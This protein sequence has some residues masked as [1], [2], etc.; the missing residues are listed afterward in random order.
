MM[1]T[2][3]RTNKMS[4]RFLALGLTLSL[5]FGMTL[6]AYASE[7]GEGGGTTPEVTA[8]A[9]SENQTP[10]E[11]SA[12]VQEI[13]AVQETAQEAYD[14]NGNVTAETMQ[15]TGSGLVNNAEVAVFEILP[16]SGEVRD[17]IIDNLVIAEN[18]VMETDEHLE[19]AKGV[20]DDATKSLN[21]LEYAKK[22]AK[23]AKT[24]LEGDYVTKDTATTEDAQS[25][26]DNAHI[27]NTIN[28]EAKAYA[29]KDAAVADLA[30]AETGLLEATAVYNDANTKI[31]KAQKIYDDVKA[32]QQALEAKLSEL[33][34]ELKDAQTSS[35]AALEAM[36]G[37]QKNL[38]DLDKEAAQMAEELEELKGIRDQYYAMM[39]QYYRKALGDKNA[40]F[41][42][43]GKLNIQANKEKITDAQ[44]DQ[45]AADPGDFTMRLGR[46]LLKQLVTYVFKNDVRIDGQYIDP[47]SIEFGI[48][49]SA[50]APATQGIVYDTNQGQKV[51]AGTVE[52]LKKTNSQGDAGR[53]NRFKV[54]YKNENDEEIV[55]YYNYIFKTSE[56]AKENGLENGIIYLALIEQKQGEDGK[57]T[58]VASQV[59]SSNNYDNYKKLQ[60]RLEALQSAIDADENLCAKVE[61]YEAA[62]KA[63][64][65]ATA[66]VKDL[67]DQVNK[68]QNKKNIGTELFNLRTKELDAAKEALAAATEQKEAME[69]KV[70]EARRAVAGINLNRFNVVPEDDG[71][72]TTGTTPDS[73]TI[74]SITPGVVITPILPAGTTGTTVATTGVAGAAT[75]TPA[76]AGIADLGEA[77]LPGA[78]TPELTELEDDLLPAAAEAL[79]NLGDK[80]LP[81]AEGVE[82]GMNLWWIW[83]LILLLL[84]VA[85]LIYRD[86]QKKKEAQQNNN[87]NPTV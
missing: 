73:P 63:V 55:K 40:V 62:K 38:W 2:T 76:V 69:A 23:E 17:A 9:A 58:W 14:D 21:D 32:D 20:V 6:T 82:E 13:A 81:G 54:K 37:V 36:K 61:Q 34:G 41:D 31:N 10:A 22:L 79:T 4:K 65:T 57:T 42:E 25:A 12:A 19:N 52:Q 26:I 86:Q 60:D 47:D 56:E 64:D 18:K 15:G 35:T 5:I 85:Y 68:L 24:E 72:E 48:E 84:I 78:A 11:P 50:N 77:E 33:Q 45:M 7:E 49:G 67:T 44:I 30:N 70:E 27:A 43:N 83:L 71:D 66:K 3:G 1:K 46:N 8:P 28:S 16:Q 39:I 59:E 74:A 51:K 87:I 53:T 80:D 75:G 29:A